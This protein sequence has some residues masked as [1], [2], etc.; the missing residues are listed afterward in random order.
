MRARSSVAETRFGYYNGL[1]RIRRP[2]GDFNS[3][4]NM[5]FGWLG[6]SRSTRSS[7]GR[8]LGIAPGR[9]TIAIRMEEWRSWHEI[10]TRL[11]LDTSGLEYILWEA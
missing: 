1:S 7:F 6:T 8:D 2:N 3:A 11:S 9:L 5:G 4:M 10:I